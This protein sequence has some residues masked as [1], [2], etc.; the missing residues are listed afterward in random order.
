MTYQNRFPAEVTQHH[1]NPLVR[2]LCHRINREE[3]GIVADAERARRVL[4]TA[5]S[6][7]ES[8][9][10]ME[11]LES[12]A[13]YTAATARRLGARSALYDA[14]HETFDKEHEYHEFLERY[15]ARELL[16]P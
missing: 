7:I 12:A 8:G 11:S 10:R 2:H 3:Q 9:T 4:L 15:P 16:E 1:L 6:A 5:I 13:S 14:L